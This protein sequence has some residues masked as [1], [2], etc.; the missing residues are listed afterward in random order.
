M[1]DHG[2]EF[3][4]ESTAATQPTGIEV[5][6]Q[7]Q[8][9]LGIITQPVGKQLVDFGIKTTGQIE[10]QPSKQTEISA[11]TAGTVT[12]LLVQPGDRVH[13]GQPVAYISSPELLELRADSFGS[14]YRSGGESKSCPAELQK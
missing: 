10:A 2:G 12:E 7:T 13:K 3:S 1:V 11:P 8:K 5:D 14:Q 6:Q 9:R 4:H